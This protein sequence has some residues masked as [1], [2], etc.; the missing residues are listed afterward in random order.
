MNKQIYVSQDLVSRQ[1][2]QPFVGDNDEQVA[3]D[4]R[5]AM[6]AQMVQGNFLVR[7][8]VVLAVACVDQ[9]EDAYKIIPY[10]VPRRVCAGTD[11][12]VADFAELLRLMVPITPTADEDEVTVD[13]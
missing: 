8:A 7:D 2:A 5:C 11:A 6:A 12:E 1:W 9:T 13:A 3:R 4:M 10:D